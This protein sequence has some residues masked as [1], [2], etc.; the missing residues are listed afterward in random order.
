MSEAGVQIRAMAPLALITGATAGI[1]NV[2]ADRLAGRGCDLL[3]VARDTVRLEHVSHALSAKY[4]VTAEPFPADLCRDDEIGRLAA[5]ISAGPPLGFLVNNAGFGSEGPIAGSDPARQ[6]QMVH[7][8]AVAPLQ[9]VQAALP[10]MLAQRAGA[11][12]NVSS[13][14]SF[15]YAPYN[16]TYAA[17][18]AFL[19][20]FTEGLAG[21]VVDSGIRVQALCP[22]FTRTEFH[23]RMG[24]DAARLHRRPMWLS[25]EYV[26][27]CSLAAL[28]R[29]GPVV[30]IPDWR[31]RVLVGLIRV[32]PRRLIGAVTRHGRR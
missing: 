2:F 28:D 7:V 23:D 8:H 4:A 31:Y 25:P 6:A 3:L 29:R 27:D 32:A 12:V 26:V 9:L 15:V 11:I 1:G 21:E 17:T 19:T 20:V 24:L 10:A 22:G 14:A 5:R 16:A 30:C 13:V 18:K